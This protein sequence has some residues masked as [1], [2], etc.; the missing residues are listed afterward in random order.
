MMNRIAPELTRYHVIQIIHRVILHQ[1]L[2]GLDPISI[3]RLE[4]RF[5]APDLTLYHQYFLRLFSG[6]DREYQVF[7]DKVSGY[8]MVRK[9]FSLI[10]T[11]IPYPPDS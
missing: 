8:L 7:I 11:P 9:P 10:S 2:Q 4:S 5:H 6:I 1:E 3:G